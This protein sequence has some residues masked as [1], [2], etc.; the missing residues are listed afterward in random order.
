MSKT[1]FFDLDGVLLDTEPLYRRFWMEA[2]EKCGYEMREKEALALRSLDA[3]LSRAWFAK[4]YGSDIYDTVRETR[5]QLM[6]AYREDHKIQAKAGA[7]E[8]LREMAEKNIRY[9]I[10]TASP[11]SRVERYRKDAGLDLDP[12]RV[13]STKTI[14]RGKPYPD[15]Y[16]EAQR[17]ADCAPEEA[18][19][20]EDSPNGIRS[21]KA[22]GC[23][24]IM[25]PDLTQPTEEDLQYCDRV[26]QD[27]SAVLSFAENHG[28][29]NHYA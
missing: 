8:L 26:L 3:S 27:L 23:F 25:I 5:K 1:L 4:R 14:A 29:E 28:D 19:A 11:L 10:V 21:A 15:V 18:V 16:L 20:I 24:T 13:I 2:I 12:A 9:F 17:I 7:V 6:E 22:A